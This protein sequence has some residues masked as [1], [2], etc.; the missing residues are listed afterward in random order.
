[1]VRTREL[2][3]DAQIVNF[4]R[5]A[6]EK[7][8]RE[9][10]KNVIASMK[11]HP[12]AAPAILV[13]KLKACKFFVNHKDTQEMME[14]YSG[15]LV[16][17]SVQTAANAERL[18]RKREG[19]G[20]LELRKN[21]AFTVPIELI[22]CS[23]IPKSYRTMANMMES[24]LKVSVLPQIDDAVLSY[25]N[26]NAMTNKLKTKEDKIE[27]L[28]KIV[29]M[30]TG[31]AMDFPVFGHFEKLQNF[32]QHIEILK[33]SRDYRC[34]G[35]PVTSKDGI[36]WETHGIG[37]FVVNDDE[38]VTVRQKFT[39]DTVTVETKQLPKHKNADQLFLAF[40]WSE[41]N[42]AIAS[43]LDP[44]NMNAFCVGPLLNHVKLPG[45]NSP[46]CLENGIVP[47]QANRMGLMLA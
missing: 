14:K 12:H 17:Q 11:V 18:K 20:P 3:G 9:D 36:N 13:T 2:N 30:G 42:M 26:M 34:R 16:P 27:A 24:F 23:D 28:Q 1:M 38:S 47:Q 19:G 21:S 22:N 15:G 37:D 10:V 44:T 25:A 7:Q 40:N 8:S 31:L 43:S 4:E 46:L 5:R 35:L 39:G 33:I 41:K 29:E 45:M 32:F 6:V